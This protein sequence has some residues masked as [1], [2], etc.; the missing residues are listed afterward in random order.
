MVERQRDPQKQAGLR[1]PLKWAGGKRWLVPHIAP[2]WECCGRG[3][4]VEPFC[5][6]LAVAL[7]LG[8]EK[9]WANDVN[10][11]LINFYSQLKSGLIV[12]LPMAN[13]RDLYYR[14]RSRF[15]ELAKNGQ[16]NTPEA[17]QLF[18]YLNR[19]G[20]NGLCRFNKNG[21]FNVPF[22]RYKAIN[23]LTDFTEYARA[24]ARWEF[25]CLDFADMELERTMSSTPIR[26]TT[27]N[28]PSMPRTI[29]AGK[30]RCGWPNG[31]LSTEAQWCCRTRRRKESSNFTAVWGS[32]CT[33]S[34]VP[35]GYP[36][37]ETAL[38]RGKSWPQ[39]TSRC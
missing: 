27:L 37:T 36:V 38:R 12:T 16:H 20:Y 6:G 5:G 3:R 17:A 25:T 11:H 2:I 18:Y 4:L 24:F 15:N 10:P 1:P 31:W 30:T 39:E 23:Y 33:S 22:G 28:S 19:T 29:S 14:Y 7:A 26:P 9:V 8:P 32:S 21:E 35:A 34:R 13:D